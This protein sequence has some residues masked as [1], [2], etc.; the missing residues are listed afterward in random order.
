M[1]NDLL[2]FQRWKKRKTREQGEQGFFLVFLESYGFWYM[3]KFIQ[4]CLE[5]LMN[6]TLTCLSQKDNQENF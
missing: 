2:T 4:F 1:R 5:N 3:K 6:L